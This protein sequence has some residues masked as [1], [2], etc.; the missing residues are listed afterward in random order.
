[1][2]IVTNTISVLAALIVLMGAVSIAE[3]R[4][5]NRPVAHGVHRHYAYH[6]VHRRYGYYGGVRRYGYYGGVRPYGYYGGYRRYGYYG[7]VGRYGYAYGTSYGAQPYGYYGRHF[8][9]ALR[10]CER[11][12]GGVCPWMPGQVAGAEVH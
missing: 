1:M 12:H 11:R 2:K 7:G 8:R 5:V 4:Y 10:R 9:R 3:A 6:G